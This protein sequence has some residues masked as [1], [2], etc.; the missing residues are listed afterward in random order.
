MQNLPVHNWYLGLYGQD[1]WRATD[2]LTFN[3]GVRWEPYFGQH[4]DS[5][6]VSIFSL[7]NFR[8]GVKS[9]VFVNAPAGLIYPGDPG[10]RRGRPASTSSGG[11]SRRARAWRGMS[12]ATGAW[13]FARRTRWRTTSCPASITTSTRR[14]RR[15]ATGPHYRSAGP[16]GRPVRAR[17]RRSASDRDEPE[18]ARTCRSARFG[19]MDPDINSPRVQN[20]NVTRR[21]ADWLDWGV[22]VSYLGSYSDRLWSTMASTLASSWDSGRAPSRGCPT[23]SARPTPT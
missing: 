9:T 2:R 12:P 3:L 23:R 16:D 18:H 6:A 1:T 21:A 17:G 4:V 13:R 20:W 22:A 15:S 7:D 10:S 8:S 11:T 14:R 5:N 19:T